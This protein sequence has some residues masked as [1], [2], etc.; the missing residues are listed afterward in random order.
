[1]QP[2]PAASDPNE[3]LMLRGLTE[4]VLSPGRNRLSAALSELE[5]NRA[6][7]VAEY[8]QEKLDAVT[9]ALA[10]TAE[11][12]LAYK[13]ILLSGWL[14][15]TAR[16][17]DEQR[18]ANRKWARKQ[19]PQEKSHKS[20]GD[21]KGVRSQGVRVLKCHRLFLVYLWSNATQKLWLFLEMV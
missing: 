13:N 21:R 12:S 14:L 8:I 9:T 1:M 5:R 6:D 18:K 4:S 11:E 17:A 19:T 15:Q 16:R 20:R 10:L 7:T 3:Q 2:Q